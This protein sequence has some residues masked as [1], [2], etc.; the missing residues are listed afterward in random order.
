VI[1]VDA[2]LGA[3]RALTGAANEARLWLV[4]R[5]LVHS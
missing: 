2:S 5:Q 3:L 1:G 4:S